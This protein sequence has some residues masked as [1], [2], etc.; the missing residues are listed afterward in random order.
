M[1]YLPPLSEPRRLKEGSGEETLMLPK[2]LRFLLKSANEW[3]L[4]VEDIQVELLMGKTKRLGRR[5][6]CLQSGGCDLSDSWIIS[7][8]SKEI[9]KQITPIELKK[10]PS[11]AAQRNI[12]EDL[13]HMANEL[14]SKDQTR[15]ICE[16]ASIHPSGPVIA[17]I[18]IGAVRHTV[19]CI[20]AACSYHGMAVT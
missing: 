20:L 4:G 8:I 7:Y 10:S 1:E 14:P 12:F 5:Y 3:L 15:G 11:R 18:A 2:Q 13:L 9:N 17:R 19:L 6:L 16:T